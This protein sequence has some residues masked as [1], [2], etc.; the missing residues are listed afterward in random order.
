[1]FIVVKIS[2]IKKYFVKVPKSQYAPFIRFGTLDSH[3]CGT[4]HIGLSQTLS[5]SK[6]FNTIQILLKYE[7]WHVDKWNEMCI[8]RKKKLINAPGKLLGHF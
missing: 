4:I 7:G 5:M 1:M 8:G 6:I 2:K 3:S